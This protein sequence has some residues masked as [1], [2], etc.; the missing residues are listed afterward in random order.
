MTAARRDVDRVVVVHG[1]TDERTEEAL[2]AVGLE[3]AAEVGDTTVWVRRCSPAVA[4]AGVAPAGSPASAADATDGCWRLLLTVAEAAAVLGVGRTTAYGLI[5]GG[6][7]EVVHIGRVARVPITAVQELV[8][9][10]RR[11]MSPS[12]GRGTLK[13]LGPAAASQPC[14]AV[15]SQPPAAVRPAAS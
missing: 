8:D 14:A 1:R 11:P 2:M 5:A 15:D 3:V 12:Q 9:R 6:Q 7:L 4:A 13:P 10:L